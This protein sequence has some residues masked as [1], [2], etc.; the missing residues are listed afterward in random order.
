MPVMEATLTASYAGQECVSRFNFITVSTTASVTLSLALAEA[1]GVGGTAGAFAAGSLLESIRQLTNVGVTY[2]Q[3][4]TRNVYSN[5]DFFQLPFV[6]T[7]AGNVTAEGMPPFV[8]YG[9]KSSQ[10]RR[11]VRRGY[12]RF[13]GVSETH[14]GNTGTLL[15]AIL[16]GLALA[17]ATALASPITYD[18]NGN[19]I[20]FDPAI[21]SKQKYVVP[22]SNPPREAYRYYPTEAAQIA[23]SATSIAWQSYTDAR[24]QSTRQRGRGR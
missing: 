20:T 19:V 18:D 23:Q 2:T 12:K 14:I 16:N 5:V 17:V 3:L 6:S 11:D 21:C 8:A 13:V 10:S 24:S 22:N 7:I 1:M 4:T 15:P 9:F